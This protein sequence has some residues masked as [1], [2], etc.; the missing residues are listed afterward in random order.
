[1]F[2]G[3]LDS[4]DQQTAMKILVGQMWAEPRESARAL[5]AVAVASL[6]LRDIKKVANFVKDKILEEGLPHFDTALFVYI[7]FQLNARRGQTSTL[8]E[9][10]IAECL[11]RLPVRVGDETLDRTKSL[12]TA[13][14]HIDKPEKA[15]HSALLNIGFP[16]RGIRHYYI[17]AIIQKLI[18]ENRPAALCQE[19]MA[20][21]S[22][23]LDPV[24]KAIVEYEYLFKNEGV[25]SELNDL[26]AKFDQL[27]ISPTTPIAGGG[28]NDPNQLVDILTD[29]DRFLSIDIREHRNI[30]GLLGME[31]VHFL[32]FRIRSEITML[33]DEKKRVSS[34]GNNIVIEVGDFDLKPEP[35]ID[36]KALISKL[37]S[38]KKSMGFSYEY[39]KQLYDYHIKLQEYDVIY[40]PYGDLHAILRDILMDVVHPKFNSRKI[41]NIAY[42]TIRCGIE[43]D[44]HN[45]DFYCAHFENIA[46]EE[47]Y[48]LSEGR[49][50]DFIRVRMEQ[51]NGKASFEYNKDTSILRRTLRFQYSKASIKQKGAYE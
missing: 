23:L 33:S 42:M 15:Y 8:Y 10:E 13:L 12:L 18:E 44:D 31:F 24:R 11:R 30:R 50:S 5:I 45:N 4:Q 35:N 27:I 28:V 16:G 47:E 20:E 48:R 25:M 3:R 21:L 19:L 39:D 32:P 29:I 7:V 43:N 9:S 37:M 40:I 36:E 51:H 17:Y 26:F 38:K 2:W 49:S 41:K 46:S 14:A 34:E 1:M 6:R 22:C